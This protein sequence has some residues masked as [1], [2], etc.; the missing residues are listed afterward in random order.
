MKCNS[1]CC[2]DILEEPYWS[3]RCF[4][5]HTQHP[6]ELTEVLQGHDVPQFGPHGPHCRLFSEKRER[7]LKQRRQDARSMTLEE[8]ELIMREG[9]RKTRRSQHTVL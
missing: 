4:H 8:R 5:L 7:R 3:E 1:Q 6:I 2:I 9:A